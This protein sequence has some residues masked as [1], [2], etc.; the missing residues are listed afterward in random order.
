MN[1][2]TK[3]ISGGQTG[4]D[5]AALDWAIQNNI[6]YGGWCPQG[7]RAEDGVIPDRYVLQETESKG[8]MQRTKWNVRDSDAT[9]IITLAPELVGGSLF[10]F[11]YAKKMAK[12]CMHIHPDDAWPKQIKHFL[13]SNL[14]Q[15]LNVAGPRCSNAEGIEHFVYLVLN[16]VRIF[17]L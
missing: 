9:L 17:F 11:E 10:T 4:A 1:I 16:E 3:I 6:V 8:Y 7:R 12:P 5:R 2:L 13:E 15:V 14:I